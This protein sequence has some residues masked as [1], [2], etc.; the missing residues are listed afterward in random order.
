MQKY[1]TF[2]LYSFIFTL[3]LSVQPQ[4]YLAQKPAVLPSP[5]YQCWAVNAEG[6]GKAEN[7]SDNESQIFITYQD[8]IVAAIN[9]K[10]GNQN[11][12]TELG[13]SVV[14]LLYKNESLYVVSSDENNLVTLRSLSAATGIAKWQKS[15]NTKT[16]DTAELHFS[17]QGILFFLSLNRETY[18]SFRQK[19]VSKLIK[20]VLMKELRPKLSYGS[21][22]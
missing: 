11:W 6:S 1:F 19:P 2:F 12:K 8:G 5:L 9:L 20:L 18:L 10:D 7:E 3:I 22:K 13:G 16:L 17:R 14:V 4:K 15:V 21:R